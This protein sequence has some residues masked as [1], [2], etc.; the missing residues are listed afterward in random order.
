MS[1]LLEVADI[2][3]SFGGNQVLTSVSF[4]LEKGEILG[5]LGLGESW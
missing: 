1:R 2:S 5:L 4:T 3:K